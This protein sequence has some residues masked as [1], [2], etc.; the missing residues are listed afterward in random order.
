MGA[1]HDVVAALEV[2]AAA[3]VV[4]AVAAPPP[5]VV[6]RPRAEHGSHRRSEW[7]RSERG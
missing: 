7:Q 3:A 6:L 4:V 2:G 5:V 1:V